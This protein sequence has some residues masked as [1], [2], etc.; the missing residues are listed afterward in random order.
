M[1]INLSLCSVQC[2]KPL[3]ICLRWDDITSQNTHI[4]HRA[5]LPSSCQHLISSRMEATPFPTFP[6]HDQWSDRMMWWS[7]PITWKAPAPQGRPDPPGGTKDSISSPEKAELA[8]HSLTKGTR[9]PKEAAQA[10][11]FLVK[12]LTAPSTSIA[13]SMFFCQTQAGKCPCSFLGDA[14]PESDWKTPGKIGLL[15]S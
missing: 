8:W 2:Y 15:G 13:T 4:S 5:E 12:F 11:P 7:V 1:D 10:P 9:S 3:V 14:A 6:S